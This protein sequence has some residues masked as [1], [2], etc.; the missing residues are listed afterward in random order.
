MQDVEDLPLHP[1]ERF[2]SIK[3]STQR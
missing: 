3:R 1:A 2:P